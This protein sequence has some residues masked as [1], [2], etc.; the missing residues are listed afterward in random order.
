MVCIESGNDF[1]HFYMVH[2]TRVTNEEFATLRF[3]SEP[4]KQKM[5][6]TPFLVM[7]TEK[8]HS[9]IC[10]TSHLKFVKTKTQE[11][12]QLKGFLYFMPHLYA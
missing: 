1:T 12:L 5:N 8:S 2:N 10:R 3:R 4:K 7:K 9:G 6:Q 11:P